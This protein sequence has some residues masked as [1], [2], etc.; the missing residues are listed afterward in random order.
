MNIRLEQLMELF[1]NRGS[2]LPQ[3]CLFDKNEKYLRTITYNV[4]TEYGSRVI[5]ESY[6]EEF[7]DD[8]PVICVIL[9]T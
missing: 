8:N 9:D 4:P 2:V 1:S 3:F 6:M 5:L 7:E